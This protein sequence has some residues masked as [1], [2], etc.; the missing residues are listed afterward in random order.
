MKDILNRTEFEQSEKKNELKYIALFFGKNF[1]EYIK[2]QMK[3]AVQN[4]QTGRRRNVESTVNMSSFL[5]K[6]NVIV[7]SIGAKDFSVILT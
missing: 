1:N 7:Q 2:R 6:K 3:N 4:G 5:P